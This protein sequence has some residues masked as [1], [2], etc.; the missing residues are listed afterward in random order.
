VKRALRL[1]ALAAALAVGVWLFQIFFPGDEKLIRKLLAETARTAEVQPNENPLFKLA[2]ANK[3]VNF[4]TP[5]VVI[6]LDAAGLDARAINGRDDFLQ[7]VTAARASLQGARFQL[8]EVHVDV[9]P[10][11]QS[12]TAQLVAAAYLNGGA[13]PLVEELKMRLKKIDG[14][15]KI[16]AAETVKALGM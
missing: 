1:V 13:D 7:A 12:A 10:D 6:K 14:R 5:D 9:A 2:A 11:K 15:W 4:F 16:A 3:L 8:H